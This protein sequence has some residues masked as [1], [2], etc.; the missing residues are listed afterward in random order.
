[1]PVDSPPNGSAA[2]AEP[3]HAS[4]WRSSWSGA[5]RVLTQQAPVELLRLPARFE[6][7]P[8]I[9]L[10]TELLVPLNN[11]FAMSQHTLGFHSQWNRSLVRC[12]DGSRPFS[13]FESARRVARFEPE[14]AHPL[15]KINSHCSE[16]PLLAP[17]P[18]RAE[19]SQWLAT[20]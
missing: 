6:S 3:S 9:K 18:K 10:A 1:M 5:H 12:V 2:Q 19:S 4:G 20:E 15:E 14:A 16:P 8:L 13:E 17:R 7:V 11:C